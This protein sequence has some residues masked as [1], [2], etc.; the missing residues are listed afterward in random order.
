MSAVADLK[1]KFPADVEETLDMRGD[2]TV[3]V[4]REMLTGFMKKMRDDEAFKFDILMDLFAVDYLHWEEKADRFEVVYS[5]YSTVLHHRLFVKVRLSEKDASLDSV[6]PLWPAA[7]WFERET[8]DMFGIRFKGHPDL[9]R[10]LMYEGFEGHALR[11]D[12]PYNKRQ[13][14][15]GPMN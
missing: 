3:Y 2:A 6:T 10:L 8:W 5:L 13:P 12:Y 4:K 9:K 11:K 15:L 7:N 1:T 14:L